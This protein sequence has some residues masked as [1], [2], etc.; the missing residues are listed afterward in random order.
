MHPQLAKTVVELCVV[1]CHQPAVAETAQVFRRKERIG[2]NQTDRTDLDAVEVRPPRL[3]AVLHNRHLARDLH[4]PIHCRRLAKEM[5]RNHRARTVTDA[6]GKVFRVHA[7]V[8][9]ID[10][11]KDRSRAKA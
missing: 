2:A 4:D 1:R 10:I 7:V 8:D 9:G 3:R 5:D 11:D 6:G